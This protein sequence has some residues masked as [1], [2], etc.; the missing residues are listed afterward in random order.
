MGLLSK[1]AGVLTGGTGPLTGILGGGGGGGGGLLGPITGIV[2][3]ITGSTA[4][5]EA[6]QA[7]AQM[8][9]ATA[10]A[11]IEEQRRQFDLTQ[12]LLGPFVQA[13]VGGEGVGGALEAQQ[14]LLGLLGPEA[15]QTAISG[16][17][18]SPLFTSLVG[19]GE[20]ALLQG[21][22]ATGGLRGGNIQ[23]ALA[24]FRPAMLQQLIESQ[25]G[26]LGGLTQLGQSSAV[27]VGA[28]G[29][30]T[31]ANIADLLGQKG[32]ALAGGIIGEGGTQARTFQ[33]IVGL[34]TLAAK[35]F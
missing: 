19:Q 5:G 8:Q 3:G 10:Q 33:D 22:S 29:Q 14:A 20:E 18:G 17:E 27:G 35:A 23:G 15:Q 6:A 9:A 32:A 13:G 4:A 11:G 21:A 30:A 34:G 25:Y 31:G 1:V 2:G 7:A 26:K 28:A 24:Q 12:E 16:L